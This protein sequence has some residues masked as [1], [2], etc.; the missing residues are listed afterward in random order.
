MSNTQNSENQILFSGTYVRPN[1][2]MPS[3][4]P[5][6]VL[7]RNPRPARDKTVGAFA[8]M[9]GQSMAKACSDCHEKQAQLEEQGTSGFISSCLI[10]WRS[11][12]AKSIW[13]LGQSGWV[14]S[15]LAPDSLMGKRGEKKIARHKK[16]KRAVAISPLPL[17]PSLPILSPLCP[18]WGSSL[19]KYSPDSQRLA[20]ISFEYN[21][22]T[23]ASIEELQ[24]TPYPCTMCLCGVDISVL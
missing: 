9:Y 7:R 6:G 16:G 20:S 10:K 22:G 21:V 15:S 3:P 17:F 4:P 8:S 14:M 24:L 11:G 18:N 19:V 12:L 13:S 5:S 23:S 2:G 1:K